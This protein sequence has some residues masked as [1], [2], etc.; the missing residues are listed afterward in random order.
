MKD[1]RITLNENNRVVSDESE[2]VE[3]FSRY[4]ENI[5][6][7]LKI[8]GLTSIPSDNDTVTIRKA[9]AKYQNHR[10]IEVIWEN[11]DPNNNFSFDLINS[12]CISKII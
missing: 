4:F 9:I 2:L 7:K 8:H 3:I 1:E 5:A 11:I 6:Q 10:S 12:E